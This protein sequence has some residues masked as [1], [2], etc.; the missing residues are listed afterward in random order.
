MSRIALVRPSLQPHPLRAALA[1]AGTAF[2]EQGRS[3]ATS[4]SDVRLFLTAWLGGL[5]FFGTYLA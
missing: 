2:A 4:G 1:G 5:V 3:S